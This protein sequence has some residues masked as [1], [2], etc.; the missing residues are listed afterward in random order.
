MEVKVLASSNTV[1]VVQT[2]ELPTLQIVSTELLNT[3]TIQQPQSI[4]ELEIIAVAG[5]SVTV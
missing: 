3:I 5:Q 2:D 1:V 4:S